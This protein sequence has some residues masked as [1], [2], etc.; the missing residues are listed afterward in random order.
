MVTEV[1]LDVDG[2]GVPGRQ[3]E[4]IAAALIRAGVTAWRQTPQGNPRGLF[5]GMGVCQDCVI[6][7]DGQDQQRA[8][9]TKVSGAHR[10]RTRPTG[11]HAA[12]LA[13]ILATDLPVLGPDVLVI[14]GGA[15]GLTAATTAATAGAQV[16][17]IDE[18]PQLGGQFYKQP[19][20]P[21][22]APA[23]RQARD[24][25]ALIRRARDAGVEILGGTTAWGAFTPLTIG[26]ATPAGSS[27][28][29]PK[30]LIV[31]TGAY[32]RGLP[33]PGWTLPGVMTT[34]AAQTLL[35][36]DG[37]VAGRRI[38]VCGH[39][40]FNLQVARELSRAGARIEAVVEL[41]DRPGTAYAGVLWRMLRH[42]PAL[43]WQGITMRRA[44]SRRGV[45]IR[46]G[47][48]LA[49]VERQN[50][51]LRATLRSGAVF[52]IDIVLMGYG[53]MP[54]NELLLALG[55]RH[56]FDAGRGHL[57]TR[58]DADCQTSVAGVFGVGD[59]CGLGGARAARG[60]RDDRRGRCRRGPRPCAV[61]RPGP[62]ARRSDAL[63]WR[64]IASSRRALWQLFAAPRLHAEL[65]R[66]DTIVC[67]C[68]E[69]T[70]GAIEAALAEDSRASVRSSGARA[71]GMGACQGR[72]CAPLLAALL[73]AS[74]RGGRWTSMRLFRA[75]RAGQSRWRSEICVRGDGSDDVRS[76]AAGDRHRRHRRRHRRD[77][78]RPGSSPR[79]ALTSRCM[80]DGGASRARPPMPA[81]CTCRCRAASCG[82]IPDLVA[83]PGAHAA[84]LSARGART[85]RRSR[86]R[87]GGDIELARSPAA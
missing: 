45:R 82:S 60:G 65:A 68:E 55:C 56:D 53:F 42:A 44:L 49:S 5:C 70:L 4:S 35:R 28:I 84:A 41:A 62:R 8:C 48:A 83:G 54:S 17:L 78:P 36:T 32:E 85:G 73:G 67:R 12:A 71:L 43:L 59:C 76:I 20:D 47:D 40:P 11:D 80:D 50:G 21:H 7:V 63:G 52:T 87:L 24:G 15:G 10:I 34:G 81:A 14:G 46:H 31:A 75:A 16:M 19:A 61:G 79:P 3:G 58:R 6:S 39:G 23:D 38:L 26:A 66:S 18:R 9:M 27:L 25:R 86:A 72:Y 1:L 2:R 51:A 57:V 37:V 13:P 30:Q 69:V 77:V 64:G 74:A 29:R 33:V 22:A